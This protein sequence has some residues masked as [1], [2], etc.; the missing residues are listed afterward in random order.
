MSGPL[1]PD[2]Q[3]SLARPRAAPDTMFSYVPPEQRVP[4][5]HPLR[6]IRTM[7]DTALRELSPEFA[8]LSPTPTARRGK[9]DR[10]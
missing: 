3:T 2:V 7:V 6:A 8:R 10:R 5:D 1:V 9:L 4:V